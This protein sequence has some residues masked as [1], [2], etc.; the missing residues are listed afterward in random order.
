MA[1]VAADCA[2]TSFFSSFSSFDGGE[3]VYCEGGEAARDGSA[4]V[5]EQKLKIHVQTEKVEILEYSKE[6]GL[7][8]FP[9]DKVI[10][11]AT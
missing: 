6:S 9:P 8:L 2:V 5:K 11:C 4:A 10:E 7:T 3:D 1:N